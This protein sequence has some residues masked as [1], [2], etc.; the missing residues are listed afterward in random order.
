MQ[1]FSLGLSNLSKIQ[2]GQAT[3]VSSLKLFKQGKLGKP[4]GLNTNLVT[5][6]K[7]YSMADKLEC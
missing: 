5:K 7:L 3:E 1:T 6:L 4:R 2:A